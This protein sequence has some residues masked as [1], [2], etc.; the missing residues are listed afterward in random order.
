MKK[1][2]NYWILGIFLIAAVTACAP[3]ANAAVTLKSIVASPTTITISQPTQSVSI[4]A[5]AVIERGTGTM[6]GD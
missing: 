4:N 2:L 1:L 6:P 5:I 3:A